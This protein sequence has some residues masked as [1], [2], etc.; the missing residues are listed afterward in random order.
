MHT[1]SSEETPRSPSMNDWSMAII[2][3]YS[4]S[5]LEAPWKVLGG[6]GLRPAEQGV[7]CASGDPWPSMHRRNCGGSRWLNGRG[8]RTRDAVVPGDGD[9]EGRA[10]HGGVQGFDP[11]RVCRYRRDRLRPSARPGFP[12]LRDSVSSLEESFHI[13]R[14]V[15][16]G[17]LSPNP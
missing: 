14:S 11:V 2:F 6:L 16:P 8:R 1:S 13:M 7:A 10:T 3:A 5:S 12:D 4:P 15:H 17:L 9:I